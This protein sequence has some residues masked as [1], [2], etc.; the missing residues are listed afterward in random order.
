M[1]LQGEDGKDL[2]P[3][4][5]KFKGILGLFLAQFFFIAKD[6]E[7]ADEIKEDGKGG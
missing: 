4:G 5:E 1:F 7:L 6:V 3:F 2:I